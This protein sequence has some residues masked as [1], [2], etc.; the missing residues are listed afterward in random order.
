VSTFRLPSL[1]DARVRRGGCA[2]IAARVTRIS[3]ETVPNIRRK[4]NRAPE[5]F[6]TAVRPARKK[7][8]T[9]L[10]SPKVP[11]ARRHWIEQE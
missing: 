4:K 8:E 2:A 1:Q 7:T 6:A 5:F 11:A 10:R 3:F 9:T